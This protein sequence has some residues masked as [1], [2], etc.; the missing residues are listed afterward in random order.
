M[1]VNKPFSDKRSWCLSSNYSEVRDYEPGCKSC[2]V[3]IAID[4]V[5]ENSGSFLWVPY[6]HKL[7]TYPTIE[8]LTKPYF[9]DPVSGKIF[10]MKKRFANM[11]V[12][13][14]AVINGFVW[15]SVG[16]NKTDDPTRLLVATFE[17]EE[18]DE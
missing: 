2:T 6:S 16:L 14:V 12:G 13:D 9:E 18:Q 15:R 3:L 4:D 7:S 1:I 17:A 11:R 10:D 5:V 8:K